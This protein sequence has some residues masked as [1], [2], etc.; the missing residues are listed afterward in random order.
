[1]SVLIDTHT[2]LWFIMGNP[3]LS[4]TA[5]SLI[6]N[7]DIQPFISTASWWEIAIK[8]SIGKLTLTQPIEILISEQLALNGIDLLEINRKHIVAVS[9]LPYHHGDPFDRMIIAPGIVEQF[10]IV[11]RDKAFDAYDITRLW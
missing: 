10:P 8:V 7:P 4:T 5:R 6:D 1:M 9:Q 2:L 11:S 3:K